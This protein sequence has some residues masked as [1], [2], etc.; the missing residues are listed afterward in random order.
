MEHS[1]QPFGSVVL[2]LWHAARTISTATTA[3]V[4]LL[5]SAAL[6]YFLWSSH[7][8]YTHKIRLQSLHSSWLLPNLSLVSGRVG[9]RID[10]VGC[11]TFPHTHHRIS[12]VLKHGKNAWP[13]AVHR[14]RPALTG[15]MLAPSAFLSP[16]WAVSEPISTPTAGYL[17]AQRFGYSATRGSP[18][19]PRPSCCH[20]RHGQD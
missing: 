1:A 5:P 10:G 2:L 14:S 11:L 18:R 8:P 16:T 3:A 19:P 13:F 6:R 9:C 7:T 20:L 15:T 4:D 12:S 17:A